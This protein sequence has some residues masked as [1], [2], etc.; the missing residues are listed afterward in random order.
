[1]RKQVILQN[2]DIAKE[3]AVLEV[4]TGVLKPK[5]QPMKAGF[6]KDRA[7]DGVFARIGGDIFSLYRLGEGLYFQRGIER[8]LIDDKTKSEFVS[9]ESFHEFSIQRAKEKR[10]RTVYPKPRLPVDLS[11]DPTPFSSY[12]DFDF[13]YFVHR[14]VNDPNRQNRILLQ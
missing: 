13:L 2:N 7:I 12:E 14:V 5:W 8:I 10:L 1:M 6:E 11:I 3:I 9:H 4:S